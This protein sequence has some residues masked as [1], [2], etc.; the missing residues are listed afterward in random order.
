M[1]LFGASLS[2]LISAQN[3]LS[4]SAQNIANQSSTS[5]VKNGEVIN[6]PFQPLTSVDSSVEPAGVR[7]QIVADNSE[8]LL[9]YDPNS[10]LANDEGLVATPNVNV[11]SEVVNQIVARQQFL[12]NLQLVER[13]DDALGALLDITEEG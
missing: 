7:S 2:G 8:P 6:E 11:A 9:R 1:N 3:R 12:S 13:Q 10:P 4:A 5:Q